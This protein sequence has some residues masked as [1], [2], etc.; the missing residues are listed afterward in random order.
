VIH[1]SA[2]HSHISNSLGMRRG[3]KK[4]MLMETLTSR[5]TANMIHV[6]GEACSN[7]VE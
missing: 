1:D 3:M 6:L 5:S 4:G 7:Q 2:S